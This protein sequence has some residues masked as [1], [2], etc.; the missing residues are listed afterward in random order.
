[1][2]EHLHVAQSG[3]TRLMCG[4]CMANNTAVV[5]PAD[6]VDCQL[7]RRPNL[8]VTELHV[9]TFFC[10]GVVM[11][12]WVWQKSTVRAWRRCLKRYASFH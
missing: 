4:S 11:S 8:A 7:S 5:D 9:L 3:R 2:S 6:A 12:S 10:A 1:M